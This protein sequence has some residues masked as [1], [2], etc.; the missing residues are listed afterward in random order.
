MGTIVA[1]GGRSNNRSNLSGSDVLAKLKYFGVLTHAGNGF[2]R[3][4]DL[5]KEAASVPAIP[6]FRHKFRLA[7]RL[8]ID[9]FAYV[10]VRL[11]VGVIQTL[12][13]DMGDAI[14]RWLGW[15]ASGPLGIRR[16][17]TDQN[18]TKIFPD[19]DAESRRYLSRRMW[20]HLFLM[21]CEIAWAQRRLHR[22]NWSQH[23]RYRDNRKMLELLIS[24]RPVVMV[25]GHFG[26]FEIGGY[27][28]GLMGFG[29][30]AIARRL[31]N[32]FLH[33]WVERFRGAKGQHVVDKEGCAV[34]VDQHLR[35]GGTLSLL[36]DQHAGPKGCWVDFMGVPA[37]CH[38]ALALFSLS[39]HAPMMVCSTRRIDGQPM[40]FEIAS[41]G[42]ADPLDDQEGIC[43]SVTTMTEWYNER[44]AVAVDD[45]VEQYWWLHRRWR[46]PPPKVVRRM[47]KKRE[48]KIA[49]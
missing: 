14:C 5:G 22:S 43:G 49:A 37:S 10:V 2:L 3:Q 24:E 6:N 33:R 27:Q 36:A 15:L 17:A 44:L 45:A 16:A 42:V 46:T 30:L 21:V 23:L 25:T 11:L 8:A 47:E 1:S 19:S 9:F 28:S 48:S 4:R 40:R 32:R 7:L 18:L 39:S 31:D 20:H 35:A 38:K 13:V 41:Y 34:E 26:N 29:S 12:P